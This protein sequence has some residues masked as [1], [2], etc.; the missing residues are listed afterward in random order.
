[1]YEARQIVDATDL[2]L[3]MTNKSI[4]HVRLVDKEDMQGLT[5]TLN[6]GHSWKVTIQDENLE[7]HFAASGARAGRARAT[8]AKQA[9]TFMNNH[10]YE[11]CV[12]V[13]EKGMRCGDSSFA[14]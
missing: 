1:M 4:E 6:P 10:A 13:P 9:T 12:H 5:V 2:K 11:V 7:Q 3:F 14:N 8:A